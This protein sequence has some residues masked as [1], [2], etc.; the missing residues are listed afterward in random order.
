[1]PT[2]QEVAKLGRHLKG[3]EKYPMSASY[4]QETGDFEFKKML[5]IMKADSGNKKETTIEIQDG[6]DSLFK[7]IFFG[8]HENQDTDEVDGK[9]EEILQPL[10]KLYFLKILF[11]DIGISFGDVVTDLAQGI[12]LIFDHNWNIQWSTFHYGLCVISLTWLPL[13]PLMI[14]VL[15]FKDSQYY[16]ISDNKALNIL[17]IFLLLIFFPLLPTLIFVRVLKTIF[18]DL[19]IPLSIFESNKQL[20][21]K[22]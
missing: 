2:R 3:L 4:P 16:S 12:N 10:V 14:H 17:F 8:K 5:K 21:R 11:I 18:V 1:M 6:S 9:V 15:S 19:K 20:A 22:D 7:K 13:V